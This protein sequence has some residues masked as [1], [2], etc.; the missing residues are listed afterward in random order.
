[1]DRGAWWAPWGHKES[2]TNEHT[3]KD[4]DCPSIILC[5]ANFRGRYA[6]GTLANVTFLH[7]ILILFK[8]LL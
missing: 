7:F 6:K 4:R 1:M 8:L 3:P 5:V 2:D